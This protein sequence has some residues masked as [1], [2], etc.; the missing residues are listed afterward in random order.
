MTILGNYFLRVPHIASER[1]NPILLPGQSKF[2]TTLRYIL[3]SRLTCLVVQSTKM[4]TIFERILFYSPPIHVIR[5][6]IN[7]S[8]SDIR[9]EQTIPSQN[10]T[11][12]SKIRFLY[13]GRLEYQK[14]VDI[15]IRAFPEAHSKLLQ[16]VLQVN[17]L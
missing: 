8:K 4:R 9:S 6:A 17:F 7:L 10:N 16:R 11:L 1:N 5:N 13:I 2:W 12:K 14:G 15:L 3:Y